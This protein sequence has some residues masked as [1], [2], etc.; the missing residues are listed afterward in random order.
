MSDEVNSTA[1][2]VLGMLQLGPAPATSGFGQAVSDGMTGWQLHETARA[3]VSAFWTLTRSQIYRE[4]ERM[5]AGGLV[6][7][8][9]GRGPRNA[10]RYR[11]TGAGRA[12]FASWLTAFAARGAAPDSLRSPLALTVFF[13]EFLP[14]DALVRALEEHRLVRRRRLDQLRAMEAQVAAGE[15]ADRL[16]TAVLARGIAT[17]DVL[18]AWI[19]DLLERLAEADGGAPAR[20]GA[21]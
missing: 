1:A 16:P 21:G 19:D 14:H 18:L 12:A 10:R 3:S 17:H 5:E 15:H 6:E 4:L 20:A 7:A 2:C 9:G 11:I 8:A 13:G